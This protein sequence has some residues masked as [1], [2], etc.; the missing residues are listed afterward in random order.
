VDG[1]ARRIRY[2][3][4]SVTDRC[5]Y[6][7]TYCMPEDLGDELAFEPRSAV[8]T[9]E[10]LGRVIGV[11]ARLASARFGSPVASRRSA[12]GSSSWSAGWRDPG[13]RTGRHDDQWSTCSRARGPPAAAGLQAVNVS[14]DTLDPIRFAEVTSRGTWRACSPG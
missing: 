5:N 12:R 14:L 8:L 6:R 4:V 3:R 7:C 10:E 1:F 11:F 13:D 2:L 9:F